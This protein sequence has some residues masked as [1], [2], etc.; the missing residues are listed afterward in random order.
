M[1]LERVTEF[2]TDYSSCIQMVSNISLQSIPYSY[3]D[4]LITV[5]VLSCFDFVIE[6]DFRLQ[7]SIVCINSIA[8]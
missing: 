6:P 5:S 7:S 4:D 3:Y 8:F 2:T 1:A